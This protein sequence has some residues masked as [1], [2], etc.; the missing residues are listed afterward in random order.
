[1]HGG[2]P[3]TKKHLKFQ[4]SKRRFMEWSRVSA[5]RRDMKLGWNTRSKNTTRFME[6]D[7]HE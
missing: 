5:R 3:N 6:E 4:S 1:M 7:G 2:R